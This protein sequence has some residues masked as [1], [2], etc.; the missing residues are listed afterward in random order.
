MRYIT[1]YS[2]HV[3]KS[4]FSAMRA[5]RNAIGDKYLVETPELGSRFDGCITIIPSTINI[6]PYADGWRWSYTFDL[7]DVIVSVRNT[8]G[9]VGVVRYADVA[10]W[11]GAC[12]PTYIAYCYRNG[13]IKVGTIRPPGTLPLFTGSLEELEKFISARARLAYDNKTM[14]VHGVPEAGEDEESACIAVA[15]WHEWCLKT[16]DTFSVR[17]A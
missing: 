11:Q 8:A 17:A 14:L 16:N 4:K 7:A 5:G 2:Q 10:H 13:V 15:E 12:T 6:E 1:Q 3:Y 9:T